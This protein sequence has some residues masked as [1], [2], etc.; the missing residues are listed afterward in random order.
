V[1]AEGSLHLQLLAAERRNTGFKRQKKKR[2]TILPKESSFE[3]IN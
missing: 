2:K 1:R 3:L